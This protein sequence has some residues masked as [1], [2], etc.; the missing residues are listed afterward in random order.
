MT[1]NF[2]TAIKF[3]ARAD[4]ICDELNLPDTYSSKVRVLNTGGN[5]IQNQ[6]NYNIRRVI[7]DAASKP[8]VNA[9]GKQEEFGSIA[10]TDIDQALYIIETNRKKARGLEHNMMLLERYL[11]AVV[12]NQ[13]KG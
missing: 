12:R 6:I 1:N 8:Y 3:L 13:I 9:K 11:A 2:S 5:S 10:E 4:E 7:K